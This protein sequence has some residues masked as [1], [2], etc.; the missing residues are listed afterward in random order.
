MR[1]TA[2]WRRRTDCGRGRAPATWE[3]AGRCARSLYARPPVNNLKKQKKLENEEI[4]SH[5]AAHTSHARGWNG[6]PTRRKH[7]QPWL[8]HATPRVCRRRR[9]RRCHGQNSVPSARKRCCQR[10]SMP[11]GRGDARSRRSAASLIITV[12]G[13]MAPA[14]QATPKRAP[15]PPSGRCERHAPQT[16]MISKTPLRSGSPLRVLVEL[17]TVGRCALAESCRTA[18]RSNGDIGQSENPHFRFL[19]GP[20]KPS[21]PSCRAGIKPRDLT[22]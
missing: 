6:A 16:V 19:A 14:R 1:R 10:V 22:R 2:A 18:A 20:I 15:R 21:R 3:R 5:V 8:D 7:V 17:G 12:P 9:A 4:T 11:S 13:A